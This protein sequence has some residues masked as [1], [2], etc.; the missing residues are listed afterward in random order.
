MPRSLRAERRPSASGE[1]TTRAWHETCPRSAR[2]AVPGTAVRDVSDTGGTAPPGHQPFCRDLQGKSTL[3]TCRRMLIPGGRVAHRRSAGRGSGDQQ[4]LAGR[5]ARFE[6][7]VR[8]RCVLEGIA[9]ADAD[10]ELPFAH[11]ARAPRRRAPAGAR[12]YSCTCRASAAA[13]TASRARPARW[14]RPDRA[15]R[16]R[17]RRSPSCPA[18]AA[19]SARRRTSSGRCR[20]RPRQRLRRRSARAHARGSRRSRSPR[21]HPRRVR[22]RAFSPPGCRRDHPRAAQLRDLRQ[23]QPDAAGGRVHEHRSRRARS[24]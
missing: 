5:A 9:G 19:P 22:A 10:V 2:T 12:A 16:S 11:P 24:R 17:S 15:R 8:L 7:F 3:R 21:R 23:Q 14:C 18:G 20:R 4:Q 1:D 6:V 13:R